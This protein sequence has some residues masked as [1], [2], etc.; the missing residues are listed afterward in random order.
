MKKLNF[1]IIREE[2]LETK[3][4]HTLVPPSDGE[5]GPDPFDRDSVKDSVVKWDSST[6]TW[7]TGG[8]V[9]HHCINL[10][11]AQEVVA[12]NDD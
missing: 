5:Y 11:M 4:N 2:E 6:M 7:S 12:G 8:N 10:G 3:N 1:R 9:G